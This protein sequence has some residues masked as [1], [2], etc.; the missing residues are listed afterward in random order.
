MARRSEH[1]QEQIREMVIKSAEAIVIQDGVKALTVRK[2]AVDIGYTVG[3]IYMVF[4]NM[5]D[6][7]THIKLRTLTELADYLRVDQQ[8]DPSQQLHELADQYL[9]FAQQH[10]NRWQIVFE[11]LETHDHDVPEGYKNQIEQLFIPI[12]GLLKQLRP[13]AEP[14]QLAL[15]ARAIWSAVHGVCIL[16]LNGN[17]GRVGLNKAQPAVYL[18]VENFIQGWQASSV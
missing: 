18:L 14:D 7:I 13:A 10:F 15:A 5:Q 16:Y 1:S 3:S 11:P 8:H 4:A 17:L 6:L 2:I 12:E 9:S